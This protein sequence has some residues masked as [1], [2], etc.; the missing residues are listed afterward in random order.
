MGDASIKVLFG[1]EDE[2]EPLE[3]DAWRT[4][5]PGLV[6]TPL[7]GVGEPVEGRYVITH[8]MSGRSM[9][10]YVWRS[11]AAAKRAAVKLGT[12]CDW[13]EHHGFRNSVAGDLVEQV[14]AVVTE[15]GRHI[16]DDLWGD[17]PDE[18]ASRS[19]PNG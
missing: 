13:S 2:F 5:V 14:R 10:P 15:E 6:V 12:L 17:E 16:W 11:I 4:G 9:G 18:S 1:T 3:V 19:T 8:K 7:L